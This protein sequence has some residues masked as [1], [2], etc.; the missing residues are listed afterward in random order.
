LRSFLIAN[1]G[2]T[3]VETL[4]WFDEAAHVPGYIEHSLRETQTP[5]ESTLHPAAVVSKM[6]SRYQVIGLRRHELIAVSVAHSRT[7]RKREVQS[8]ER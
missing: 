3:T 1:G 6:G 8:E 7:G 4:D 5:A 2:R